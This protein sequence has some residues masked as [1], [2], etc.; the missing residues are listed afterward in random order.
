MLQRLLDERFKLKLHRESREFSVY[1]LVVD[2]R[3]SKVRPSET[4]GAPSPLWV[5][6]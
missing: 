2:K 3:G 5:Q 6:R 1:A 4:P